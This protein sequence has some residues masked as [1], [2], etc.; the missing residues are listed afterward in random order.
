MGKRPRSAMR[1]LWKTL[2][3]GLMWTGVAWNGM[4]P[5]YVWKESA[6]LPADQ[7]C[8]PPLSEAELAQWTALVRQL[9]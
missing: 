2:A 1:S 9:Q 6:A 8:L 5:P 3:E 7:P 4:C